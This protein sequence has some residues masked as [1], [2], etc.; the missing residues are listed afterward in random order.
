MVKDDGK[1]LFMKYHNKKIVID[2]QVFDSKKEGYR[3]RELMI[4]ER[5]G[6]ITD[7]QRQVK[8]TLIP[9]QREPDTIGKRGGVK[10]G[11]LI[12][13]EVSY[14]AD[15]VY[16]ENGE[17]VVEDTKG[18]RTKDYIIKRKLMLYVHRIRIKEI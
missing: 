11:K 18:I 10:K 12:E 13:R 3:Y 16:R 5:S 7:L 1:E 17:L 8:Y 2:G 6:Q 9:A 14:I 15:F 4:L